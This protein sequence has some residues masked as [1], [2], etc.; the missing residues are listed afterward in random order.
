VGLPL[1]PA[2][3]EVLL[4]DRTERPGIK[5]KDADLIGIP[6]RVTIGAKSLERNCV[7]FKRRTDKTAQ[8]VPLTDIV[9]HIASQVRAELSA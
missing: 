5:F 8:E 1:F 7:E 4:D 6:L 2:G 3:V 9:E